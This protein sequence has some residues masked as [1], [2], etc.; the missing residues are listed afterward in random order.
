MMR[1]RS[2]N[3]TRAEIATIHRAILD[4]PFDRELAASDASVADASPTDR[5][6]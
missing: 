6:D 4:L 5:R 2:T 3:A 1:D